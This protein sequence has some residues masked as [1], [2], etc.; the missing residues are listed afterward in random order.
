MV[1]CSSIQ[2]NS[3]AIIPIKF[4]ENKNHFKN[5]KYKVTKS[6]YLWG[7][8]PDT[9]TVSLDKVFE[10]KGLSSVSSLEIQEVETFKKAG[11]MVATLG[12]YYPQTFLLKAKA[13][14]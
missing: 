5:V 3:T 9:N 11:W 14:K 4:D 7:L 13:T 10:A 1:G 12:L 6:F 2:F 8:L